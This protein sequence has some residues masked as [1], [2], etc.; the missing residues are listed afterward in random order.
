MRKVSLLLIVAIAAAASLA[1]PALAQDKAADV[2]AAMRQAIGGGKLDSLRTFSLE[3]ATARN[4][5]ERQLTTEVELYLDIPDKYLRVENV[6]APIARTMTSGFNGDKVIVPAGGAMGGMPMVTFSGGGGAVGGG[7]RGMTIATRID[8]ARGG[9]AG[10]TGEMTPEQRAM[11]DASII[12]SQR[13]ELSRLMLGWFGTAHPALKATYTYA[14]EAESPDGKAH[15]IS[16]KA[17]GGFD[18]K[19]FI[20]QATN[21]PLMLTYEAPEPRVITRTAGAPAGAPV[22]AGGGGTRGGGAGAPPPPPP[23]PP[24]G[25]QTQMTQEEIQKEIEAMRNQP[26][27]MIEHRVYFG[28]WKE[29]DGI[30]FPHSLQRATGETTTEEWTISKVKVNPKIDAKKFQ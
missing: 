25:G 8:G 22:V 16:I 7:G 29:V 12:R 4:I 27:K 3:A 26:R 11:M 15:V 18:A 19:L 9:G 21:I 10:G 24:P 28:D 13:V 1:Q 5:G 23:P 6:T 2:L 14:G 17:D 30:Q 20:D